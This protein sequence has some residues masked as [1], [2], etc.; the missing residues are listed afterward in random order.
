MKSLDDAVEEMAVRGKVAKDLI[1]QQKPELL[2]LFLTYQNEAIEARKF[3]NESLA[4]LNKQAEILEVGGGILALSIQL[5]SEGFHVTTVEPVGEGFSGISYI[6]EIFLEIS[7]SENL[8]IDLIKHPIEE[9]E[10]KGEFDFIFSINVLEHLRNPY[11]VLIQLVGNLGKNGTC[12]IF[13]PNYDFPYEPHFQKWMYQRKDGA[14]YLPLSK[15]RSNMIEVSE[16]C[17]VHSSLNFITLRKLERF[18]TQNNILYSVNKRALQNMVYRT[19]T[20]HE[21]K[22]R[23]KLLANTI[24][25]LLTLRLVGLLCF[26]PKR[27]WPIIDIELSN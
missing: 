8:Q 17:G 7:R 16:W 18:L 13:C 26:L 20:D 5:A 15:A 22:N 11:S 1:S 25:V 2:D 19:V 23:H 10:L 9:S 21:L 6:M 14:F 12:R 3:L 4:K 27:S 24:G